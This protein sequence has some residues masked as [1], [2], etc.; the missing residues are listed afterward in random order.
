MDLLF[1][2][3][4]SQQAAIHMVLHNLLASLAYGLA[5]IA[6][7]VGA[8][9]TFDWMTPGDL[10]REILEKGNIAAAVLATGF[11]L[12]VAMIVAAAFS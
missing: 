9:K 12:A 4:P 6:L 3:I 7:M 11:L 2:E 5:G 1:A 8:F 10:G